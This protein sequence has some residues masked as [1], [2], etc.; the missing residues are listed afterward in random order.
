MV[1]GGDGHGGFRWVSLF[2]AGF[3]L[4]GCEAIV[5]DG[6]LKE[7][8]AGGAESDG[9]AEAGVSDV[10]DASGSAATQS[11]GAAEA[12]VADSGTTDAQPGPDVTSGGAG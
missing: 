1:T 8:P 3:G 9:P 5:N 2:I 7:R 6:S 11:D 4:A 10:T 12:A